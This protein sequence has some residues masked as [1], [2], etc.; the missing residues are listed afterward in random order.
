MPVGQ[1]NL[2]FIIQWQVKVHLYNRVVSLT[3]LYVQA[4]LIKR[5][6]VERIGE[7]YHK[8]LQESQKLFASSAKKSGRWIFLNQDLIYGNNLI[9]SAW[10]WGYFALFLAAQI[11]EPSNIGAATRFR[12]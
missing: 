10:M 4:I 6:D 12:S 11:P 8:V 2:F 3:N 1:K 5:N 9:V 7:L